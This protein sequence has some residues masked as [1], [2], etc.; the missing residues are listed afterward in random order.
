VK[1]VGV[2][3]TPISN[4]FFHFH[5]KPMNR[6]EL[7]QNLISCMIKDMDMQTALNIVN[8]YLEDDLN[9]LKVEE[10]VKEVEEFYPHLLKG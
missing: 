6:Q 4:T 5:Q 3:K 10:I 1:P 8:D 2:I 7:Q 9:R